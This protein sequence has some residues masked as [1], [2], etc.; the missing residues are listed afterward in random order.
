M[1]EKPDSEPVS[2]EERTKALLWQFS[3]NLFKYK[4]KRMVGQN[5]TK[6]IFMLSHRANNEI[7]TKC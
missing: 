1:F 6:F 3:P 7:E 5:A 4:K 2:S